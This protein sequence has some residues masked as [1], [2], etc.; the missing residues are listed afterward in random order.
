[1]KR[2]KKIL[3]F[4]LIIITIF[5]ILQLLSLVASHFQTNEKMVMVDSGVSFIPEKKQQK[6]KQIHLEKS[7]SDI[8]KINQENKQLIS[9]PQNKKQIQNQQ[10]ISEEKPVKDVSIP[11]TKPDKEN[12]AK[13]DNKNVN[14]SLSE[15]IKSIKTPK[16]DKEDDNIKSGLK[17]SLLKK[18]ESTENSEKKV[19]KQDNNI[20]KTNYISKDRQSTFKKKKVVKEF[21]TIQLNDKKF[22]EID[23]DRDNIIQSYKSM[24]DKEGL[25]GWGIVTEYENPDIAHQ[26]LGGF[27]FA[28]DHESNTYYRIYTKNQQIQP[29]INISAYGTTGIDAHD[30]LLRKIAQ[31][32][33]KDG[34]ISS[35]FSKLK[36]YFLFLKDT[37]A[38]INGKVYQ[39]FE[40]YIKNQGFSAKNS[41]T[42]RKK[43]RLRLGVWRIIRESAGELG[44]AVPIY[45]EYSGKKHFLP[46]KY[47]EYDSE[48][49]R[50]NIRIN[51]EDY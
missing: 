27:P 35:Y 38:Y 13:I 51:P 50:L 22:V 39:I 37:E 14:D 36:F 3:G 28:I 19:S 10:K 34:N 41:D 2:R 30:P 47:Y 4:I 21:E 12:D 49:S 42:F 26:L 46:E 43:A 48:T 6:D 11:E 24:N 5:V 16:L 1:M 31:K 23:I 8:K 44:V 45:F 25:Y 7:K 17:N 40:W 9:N 33:I 20:P 18:N 32:G 29:L 15:N